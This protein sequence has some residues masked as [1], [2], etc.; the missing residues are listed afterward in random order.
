MKRIGVK[1]KPQTFRSF[2]E[3]INKQYSALQMTEPTSRYSLRTGIIGYKVGMTHFW[4]KWGM[5]VGCT[6]I[7]M[8][9][10]QVTQVKTFDKDGV[11]SIQLG[12]GSKVAH[13][14]VKA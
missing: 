1:N 4:D 11:N 10:C 12:I 3:E 13:K 7:Q 2:E 5:M 6:V 9:R 8:D 14:V